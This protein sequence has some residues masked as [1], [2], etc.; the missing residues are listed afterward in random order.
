MRVKSKYR[1][2]TM[3][4]KRNVKTMRKKNTMK[5]N[6]KK[7]QNDIEHPI[8]ERVYISVHYGIIVHKTDWN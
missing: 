6:E 3:K 5:Y 1:N 7:K 8:I 4:K 2:E